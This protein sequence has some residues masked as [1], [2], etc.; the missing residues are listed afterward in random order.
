MKTIFVMS[1]LTIIQEQVLQLHGFVCSQTLRS[2]HPEVIVSNRSD[3]NENDV[4]L[5]VRDSNGV[6]SFSFENILNDQLNHYLLNSTQVEF[7]KLIR[8]YLIHFHLSFVCLKSLFFINRG[9]CKA[10]QHRFRNLVE[11]LPEHRVITSIARFYL[12]SNSSQCSSSSY[13]L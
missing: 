8:L 4:I 11:N 7:D 6:E 5:G 12:L 1:L 2:V 13:R 3:I 9:K 10:R